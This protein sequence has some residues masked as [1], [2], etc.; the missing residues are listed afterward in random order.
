MTFYFS[1]RTQYL[2]RTYEYNLYQYKKFES[3]M[4]FYWALKKIVDEKKQ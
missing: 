1:K 2:Q 3:R 4:F